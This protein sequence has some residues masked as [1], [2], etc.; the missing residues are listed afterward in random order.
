MKPNLLSRVALVFTD[1]LYLIYWQLLSLFTN[2]D[3]DQFNKPIKPRQIAV[4]IIP[5]V[6]EPWRFMEPLT[7][8]LYDSGFPVHVID[9]LGYNVNNI[10]TSALA[11]KGYIEHIGAERIVLIAHSKGGLIGK[12]FLSHYNTDGTVE[13]LIALN[14]PFSGSVYASFTWFWILRVFSPRNKLVKELLND[15]ASNQKIT[16][17]YSV[18]DPYI[19]SGS[20][21][22][23]A[24][25]VC[26]NS[27]GH[28]RIISDKSAQAAILHELETILKS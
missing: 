21:L 15:V 23:G 6:Y 18:Y 24:E 26:I 28:F 7:S 22:E 25:N 10:P 20:R 11:L 14:T 12:Y 3:K 1:F 17:I 27:V 8:K 13:R 9:E 19:P 5:G 4:V 16:S 2:Y